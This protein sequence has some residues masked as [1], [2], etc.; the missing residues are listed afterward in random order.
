MKKTSIILGIAGAGIIG[1][2]TYIF[3]N[4]KTKKKADALINNL[5][6]KADTM[7]KNM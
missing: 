6:D 2:G 5:L 1:M 3:M 4:K 7:T